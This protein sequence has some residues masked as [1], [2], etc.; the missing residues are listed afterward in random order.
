MK[1]E[2]QQQNLRK[3]KK[4]IRFYYRSL[5][6]KQPENLD[7]IDNFLDRFQVPELNQ[8]QINNLNR[9]SPFQAAP[10]LGHLGR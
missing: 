8:D 2:I 9:T 3:L 1:R 6:S 7:E 4:I 5:Y 10:A